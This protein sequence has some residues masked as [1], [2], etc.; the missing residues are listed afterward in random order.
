M[1]ETEVR[2]KWGGGTAAGGGRKSC[3]YL[4]MTKNK[5]KNNTF[6]KRKSKVHRIKQSRE[7]SCWKEQENAR[8]HG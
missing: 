2:D 7:K 4:L 1:V 5:D 3:L 6:G 8:T